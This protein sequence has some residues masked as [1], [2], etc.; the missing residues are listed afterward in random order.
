[1]LRNYVTLAIRNLA[2]RKL[3]SFI[4]SFGL[5][6]AIAFSI[7]IYLYLQDEKSF[8]QFHHNKDHIFILKEK[9]LDVARHTKG[10][11]DPYQYTSSLP[12]MFAEVLV[13]EAPGVKHVTRF[14]NARG[15]MRY[16]DKIFSQETAYIDSEFFRM[17]SFPVL[18][19]S[20][21]GV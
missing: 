15:V 6:T 12:A 10:D 18:R 2:K 20:V 13:H 14:S 1:M 21:S 8:D 16:N 3:Y 9:H 4:N 17:F 7:L 5:S 11:K 19:G